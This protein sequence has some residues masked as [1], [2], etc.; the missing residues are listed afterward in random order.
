MQREAHKY[1]LS[2]PAELACHKY[3]VLYERHLT[4]IVVVQM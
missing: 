1:I 2:V 4:N 3:T